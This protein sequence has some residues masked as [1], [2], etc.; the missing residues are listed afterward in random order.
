MRNK[1]AVVEVKILDN[2]IG[3]KMLF[4]AKI[5]KWTMYVKGAEDFKFP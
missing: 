1:H 4:P 5:G 2:K 3:E